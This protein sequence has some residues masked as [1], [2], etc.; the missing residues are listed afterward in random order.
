MI[1][2]AEIP[3]ILIL[4]L[5]TSSMAWGRM[6]VVGDGTTFTDPGDE[7]SIDID[8]IFWVGIHDSVGEEYIMFITIDDLESVEWTGNSAVYSPPAIS[9]VP[10]WVYLSSDRWVV[11]MY[12][13]DS[14][15]NPLPGVGCAI[16]FHTLSEGSF[17]I[18][19]A[20]PIP[21]GTLP[22]DTLLVNVVPEPATVLLLALG[23]LV[24]TKRRQ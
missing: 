14:T 24:L 8:S 5:G 21:G 1:K 17:L 3:A 23:S 15:E 7:V 12:D 6:L 22:S 4:I 19:T 11:E 18:I 20:N 13:L 16:E 10:G 2:K 9:T